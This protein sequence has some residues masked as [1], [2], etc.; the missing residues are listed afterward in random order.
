MEPQAEVRSVSVPTLQFRPRGELV[1][2][3]L[4]DQKRPRH[5]GANNTNTHRQERDDAA[6]GAE[7]DDVEE[8][9]LS[10]EQLHADVLASVLSE[11]QG[12]KGARGA[13]GA[14]PSSA[15]GS[16]SGLSAVLL[17]LTYPQL[18]A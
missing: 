1:E 17:P 10:Q 2:F 4:L 3:Y 7:E 16:V 5:G 13:G 18:K 9:A 15:I 6:E 11:Q 12:E 14:G 8:D